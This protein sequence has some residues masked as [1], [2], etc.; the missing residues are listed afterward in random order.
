MHGWVSVALLISWLVGSLICQQ[1]WLTFS[2]KRYLRYGTM[3]CYEV[4]RKHSTIPTS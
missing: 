3:H 2:S 4:W 1:T